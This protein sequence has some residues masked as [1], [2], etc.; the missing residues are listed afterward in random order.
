M[1]EQG[2]E[3]KGAVQSDDGGR[4]SEQE[5]R[6]RRPVVGVRQPCRPGVPLLD[7]LENREPAARVGGQERTRLAE[8][9]GVDSLNPGRAIQESDDRAGAGASLAARGH[10]SAADGDA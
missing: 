5:H 1:V 3:P 8:G 4:P 10:A 7:A 9:S 6:K 2:H